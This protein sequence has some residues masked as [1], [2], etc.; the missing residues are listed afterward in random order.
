MGTG[1]IIF[2]WRVLVLAREWGHNSVFPLIWLHGVMNLSNKSHR[3]CYQLENASRFS[4]HCITG[5]LAYVL[6]TQLS[7]CKRPFHRLSAKYV[8]I[9]SS[10]SLKS[11]KMCYILR[12]VVVT[13]GFPVK[14]FKSSRFIHSD[15]II[16]MIQTMKFFSTLH[17]H[18]FWVQNLHQDSVFKYP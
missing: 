16:W 13:V 1:S 18:P 8:T 12:K 7:F 15:Y 10:A 9:R 17:F 4:V 11:N 3:R 14:T 2:S 6:S 5:P